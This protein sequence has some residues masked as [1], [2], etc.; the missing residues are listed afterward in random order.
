MYV[1]DRSSQVKNGRLLQYADDVLYYAQVQMWEM[2]ISYY[3]LRILYICYVE[4]LCRSKMGL[5]IEK[6]NMM[7]FWPRSL[8]S[9]TLEDIV[10]D[11]IHL[12]EY[13]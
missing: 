3:Y 9:S 1:N 10:N 5:N 6:Y 13:R 11:G 7:W 12:F 2:F 8:I 4:Y